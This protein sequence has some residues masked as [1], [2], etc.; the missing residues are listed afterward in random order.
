LTAR[1][2]GL[3]DAD[4]AAESALAVLNRLADTGSKSRGRDLDLTGL[5]DAI[6]ATPG[7]A[8]SSPRPPAEPLAAHPLRDG[9]IAVGIG[10]PFGQTDA[11]TLTALVDAATAHGATAF[12][13]APGRALLAVGLAPAEVAAFAAVAETLGFI[14]DAR[15][16]RRSVAACAGA[17]ACAAGRMPARTV[18]AS[19]AR[20]AAPILDGSVVLHVAG[21][22]KGCAHPGAATLA[23]VGTD[24]GAGL[25][26]DGKAG[27][28]P[29]ATIDPA[30][31]PDAAARLA[32]TIAT[33]RRPGET[34]AAAIRRLGPAALAAALNREPADA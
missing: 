24:A 26:V 20:A 10:L 29:S 23:L 27:D 14:V 7:P 5:A 12:V 11:A 4:R 25:V 21:C 3:V 33:A 2:L 19:I 28:P 16:P 22:A 18:A 1:P 15:D 31:L 8:I 34:S 32:A 17:P 9:T 13:P 6:G 30:A